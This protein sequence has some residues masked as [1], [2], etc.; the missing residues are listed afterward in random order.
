MC[1]DLEIHPTVENDFILPV[2]FSAGNCFINF[3]A[4]F[5]VACQSPVSWGMALTKF[6]KRDQRLSWMLSR[7]KK[8]EAFDS[9]AGSL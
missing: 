5:C 6:I 2:C 9:M 3:A 7:S 8:Q 4:A 1:S